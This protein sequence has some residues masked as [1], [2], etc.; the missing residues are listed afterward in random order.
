[1][2]DEDSNKKTEQVKEETV[3]TEAADTTVDDA[4][5]EEAEKEATTAKAGKRSAKAIREAEESAEKEERK[6]KIASGEIDA[7]DDED[8]AAQKKGPIPVT[9]PKLERRGKAYRKSAEL[10]KK[11]HQYGLKEALELAPKTSAVKFDATVELHINLGVDPRQA[12]QNIRSTVI[13]PEGTG[14]SVRV[15]VFAAADQHDDAKKAGADIVGE[16]DFIEQLKKEEINFDVLIATPQLMAQLGRFAKLLGPK[17]LMPNPKSGT[18]TKDVP[19]AVKEA[20]GGRLEYRVD[21]QGI[22]H[23]AIGKVSFGGEKLM[24]NAK[25]VMQSIQQ[26]RPASIKGTYIKSVAV[27]TSMGP[28]IAVSP[29]QALADIQ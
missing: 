8:G 22:V 21:A 13:L 6:A 12:D 24:N 18:V 28:G 25:A 27:S 9:R 16:E 5:N 4:G 14:K 11:D 10:I 29:T 17:G 2:S 1:M 7:S 26:N 19:K 23:V 15:A 20:K 3:A